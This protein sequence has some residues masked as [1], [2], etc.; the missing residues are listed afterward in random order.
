[1][2]QLERTAVQI[3]DGNLDA[4]VIVTG[5]DEVARVGNVFN[6]MVA[7]LQAAENQRE[8]LDK[9]R[10]DL[11]AW[12]SHD[13]RTP[14]TS[15][16]AMIEALN[17]GLVSDPQSV[18]RYY[19]TIRSDIIALNTLIDDLF[20][21]AQ[22][23]AGG[24]VM[25]KEIH[26]LRD[27]ISDG[28]ESF[29]ALAM[30]RYIRL[31]GDVQADLDAVP[32]NATKIGRVLSNLLS[33]ALRYTPDGG[34]IKVHAWGTET[35][36]VVTIEDSGDGFEPHDL[37]RIFE[38]F[39]RGEEAR[40]RSTGGAGLGLEIAR[41]IVLAHNGRIWAENSAEGGAIVGFELPLGGSKSV[42]NGHI[43]N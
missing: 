27:I 19:K 41:G 26:S 2:R 33:N 38:Q 39:Y 42:I 21:L 35:S 6:Q 25:D 32:L 37:P 31:T 20:E 12:T 1:L 8:E 28:L 40:S 22:L 11:I 43:S 9:L 7:Q 34:E 5:N 14:L 29:Q 13:L 18:Q 16:R 4:R 30:Q 15:I 23:D 3:A 24:L 36:A 10:R 17:D